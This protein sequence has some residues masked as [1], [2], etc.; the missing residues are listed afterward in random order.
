MLTYKVFDAQMRC[1]G[2]QFEVGRTYKIEGKPVL[3]EAGVSFLPV[4]G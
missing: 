4:S 2:F 3:C 1:R